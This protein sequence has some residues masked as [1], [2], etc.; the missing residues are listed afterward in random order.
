M[1]PWNSYIKGYVSFLRLEK[2]L[3]QNSID[4][5]VADVTKLMTFCQS[6]DEQI[7]PSK[8]TAHE[9]RLFLKWLNEIHLS[10]LSQSRIIS[11]LKS[12][13]GYLILEN[14]VTKDPMELIELPRASRNLPDFMSV[15]EVTRILEAVDLSAPAGIRDRTMLE[16]LYSCGLRVSELLDVRISTISL[17][18]GFLRVIGKG[19]K[20]RLV[21]IGKTALD[22]IYRLMQEKMHMPLAPGNEDYLFL[23]L[24]GKKTTRMTVLNIIKALLVK[25]GIHKNVTPH[26]FRHS[27]AT[28]LVEAGAD[29]RAVQEMLGHSSIT[30]TE[31][32]THLDRLRLREEILSYHPRYARK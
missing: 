6:F 23:N 12:F 7:K 32:Y 27:F 9:I 3:S 24:R 21:P 5:Y 8:V 15:E 19:N 29:L 16:V 30:T 17:E 26:T 22:W 28:H 11:G 25:T 31:I 14:I 18:E 10:P 2:S 13:F 20:E 4:A 1:N